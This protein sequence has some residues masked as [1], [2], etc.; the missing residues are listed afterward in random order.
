MT[1]NK[2]DNMD[3]QPSDLEE[4][5]YGNQHALTVLLDVLIEKGVISE[6]EFK[7]KLD[8]MIDASENIEDVDIPELDDLKKKLQ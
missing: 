6:Q 5:A 3:S 1:D 8:E 2:I 7:D 4:V